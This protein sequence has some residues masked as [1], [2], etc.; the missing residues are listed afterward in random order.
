[1]HEFCRLSIEGFR[2]LSSV[3]DVELRPLSV[4]I[5]ANGVG[6][7]SFLDVFSLL[8]A[9]ASG[10]LNKKL[11]DLNGLNSILTRGVNSDL[12]LDATMKA[13]AHPPLRYHLRLRATGQAYEISEEVLSQQYQAGSNTPFKHIDSHTLDVR[14]FDLQTK[15][16]L[17]PNWNHNPLET[18]LSQV[19]KMYQQPEALRQRLSSLAYYAALAFDAGPRSPVRLPQQMRPALL[20]GRNGEDLVPCLYSLRETDRERF[21]VIEDTLTAAFPGFDRLDFPPVAAGTLAMTW[22]D[23]NFS[24]PIYTN[25]L[26]EGILR[27]LWLVTL[28]Q[29]PG[30][31]EITLIDEAEVSLHPDLLRI[32]VELMREASSRT[33][34]VVAT[35]SERLIRFLDPREVLVCDTTDGRSTMQWAD[36]LDLEKWLSDYS[37]DELWRLGRL[38]GRA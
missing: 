22:K 24:K 11:S 31:T 7:T 20:P 8:A 18:S 30:L 33:Q 37:L 9:S 26:S 23:K 38:G 35:Q 15:G 4:L 5:G 14:Y 16:L 6:K 28:L 10:A 17:R 21:E 12:T 27:F 13:D 36:T 29:S 19:P 25:E 34:L 3:K 1:M 32:L 2:R